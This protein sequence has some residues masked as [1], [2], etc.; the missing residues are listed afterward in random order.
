MDTAIKTEIAT[1]F[2]ELV[3][4]FSSF[5]D[6]QVNTVPFAGSWTPGQVAEHILKS[7]Q[8]LP[9][10]M[11]AE[12]EPTSRAIDEKVPEIRDLF[13]NMELKMEAPE[14]NRPSAGPHDQKVLLNAFAHLKTELENA[15][16]TLDLSLT[17]KRFSMP[18]FGFLTRLE[19][20]T[21]VCTHTQRHTNQLKNIQQVLK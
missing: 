6:T 12:T 21:F 17:C 3:R 16:G 13:Q 7:A 20:L 14:F 5:D 19:W 4:V 18:G 1:T 9:K 10:L 15:A 11:T 2:D 8:G